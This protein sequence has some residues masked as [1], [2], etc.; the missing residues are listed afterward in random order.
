MMPRVLASMN[1]CSVFGQALIIVQNVFQVSYGFLA[2]IVGYIERRALVLRAFFIDYHMYSFI[3]AMDPI[4]ILLIARHD[5]GPFSA[6]HFWI[7]DTTLRDHLSLLQ[8][9]VG[10]LC[11]CVGRSGRG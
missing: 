2:L 1:K 8:H 6:F 4:G 5:K 9:F 3:N 10:C 7:S 11:G